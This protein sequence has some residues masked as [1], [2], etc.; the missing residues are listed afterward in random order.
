MSRRVCEQ[1]NIGDR[2]NWPSHLVWSNLYK[3]AP[4]AGGNPSDQLCNIQFLGCVDLFCYELERFRPKYLLMVTDKIWA[5]DFINRIAKVPD[6]PVNQDCN[7]VDHSG[8]LTTPNGHRLRVVVAKRP[9]GNPEEI[10]TNQV[11]E[12]ID[13]IR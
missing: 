11:I 9:E 3:I 12:T 4:A 6:H 10:W 7:Y 2:N 1:L 13:S 5:N 8:I